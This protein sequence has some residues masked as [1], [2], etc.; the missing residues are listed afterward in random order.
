MPWRYFL[1]PGPGRWALLVAIIGLLMVVGV[2]VWYT[3]LV[4][5]RRERAEE[6]REREWC[7]LLVALDRA[8]P[9]NATPAQRDFYALIHRLRVSRGCP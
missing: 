3:N 7:A 6:R 1:R 8:V 4:D 9:P 5:D 2:N